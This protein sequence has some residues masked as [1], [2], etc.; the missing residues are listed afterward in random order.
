MLLYWTAQVF[1]Q[2]LSD[3]DHLIRLRTS[4]WLQNKSAVSCNY[5]WPLSVH[6]SAA[7]LTLSLALHHYAKWW[8]RILDPDV[9]TLYL[10]PRIYDPYS[11]DGVSQTRPPD[12]EVPS[13]L[14]WSSGWAPGCQWLLQRWC[15]LAGGRDSVVVGVI[16]LILLRS[17]K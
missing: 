6:Y 12:S 4:Y 5:S 10:W 3:E 14:R 16:S 1:Q 9:H 17:K 15:R 11:T 2:K 8:N 13:P 7:H